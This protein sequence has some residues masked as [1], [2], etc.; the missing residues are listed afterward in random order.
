MT[1]KVEQGKEY[2][3]TGERFCTS[4]KEAKRLGGV[5][6]SHETPRMRKYREDRLFL[7]LVTGSLLKLGER[8]D[9]RKVVQRLEHGQ[10]VSADVP[11]DKVR[12]GLLELVAG[13]DRGR[14]GKDGVEFLE[15]STGR[16]RDEARLGSA[17]RK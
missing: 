4:E 7:R 3:R 8:L 12:E 2:G 17:K 9:G 14:D 6:F 16:L 11:S 15:R 1:R 10:L 5:C 13:V